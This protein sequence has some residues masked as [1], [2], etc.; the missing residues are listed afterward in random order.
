MTKEIEQEWGVWLG[1]YKKTDDE[2]YWIDGTPLAGHFS[3]WLDTEPRSDTERCVHTFT[4][5]QRRGKWNDSVCDL[6]RADSGKI[7]VILCQ[8]KL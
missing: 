2:F 4:D 3:A 6:T 7:P 1:L 8:K 5:L